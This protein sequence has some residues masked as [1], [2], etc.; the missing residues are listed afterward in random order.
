[1]S[2]D[3][4]SFDH[5]LRLTDDTGVFEHARGAVPR[6]SFGYCVDDA[7]RGLVVVSREPDP[8]PEVA[9]LAEIYLTLVSDALA[10]DGRCRNRLSYDRRWEDEPGDG[11]WW[12]RALWGLGTAGAIHRDPWVRH[13]ALHLFELAAVWRS[14]SPRAMSF[15][16]LGAA[17]I[18]RVQPLHAGARAL[19]ADAVTTIGAAAD[20]QLWPWPEPR[21]AYANAVLPEALIAAGAVT[22]DEVLLGR[23]LDLLGWLLETESRGDHLSPTPVG[24]W[25]PGEARPGFDQQPIEAAA[26]ADACARAFAVTLEPRWASGVDRALRWFLGDNDAGVP[27]LNPDTGGGYDGLSATGRNANQGAES[28]LALISTLQQSRRHA[29]SLQ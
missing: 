9:R 26:I 14:I 23:G 5:L 16:T 1:L 21:L 15:A 7:A 24:G 27:M 22:G 25:A 19:V 2:R 20:P 3:G 8:A 17:E 13:D 6:R 4:V 28:T 18:L 12:G 10:P 11:D 29:P